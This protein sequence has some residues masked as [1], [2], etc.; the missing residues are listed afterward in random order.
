MLWYLQHG[1]HLFFFSLSL[2]RG[3]FR[4]ECAALLA[5]NLLCLNTKNSSKYWWQ[6]NPLKIWGFCFFGLKA[7]QKRKNKRTK[8]FFFCFSKK[9]L[10]CYYLS[11]SYLAVRVI[12]TRQVLQ[13]LMDAKLSLIDCVCLDIQIKNC[14]HRWQWISLIFFWGNLP[15][16]VNSQVLLKFFHN[17]SKKK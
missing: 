15:R 2:W 8:Y 1:N 16:A 3:C 17:A 13:S 10:F 6:K 4:N 9:W 7:P 11:L 14:V 12:G 5:Y